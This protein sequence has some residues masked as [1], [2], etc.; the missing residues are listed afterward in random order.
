M[1]LTIQRM[2]KMYALRRI[3]M[4]K[5]MLDGTTLSY[6]ARMLSGE[7]P[8]LEPPTSAVPNEPPTSAEED[9]DETDDHGAAR[10]QRV[11]SHVKLATKPGI[12]FTVSG[13]ISLTVCYCTQN[14]TTQGTCR[15]LQ[16]ILINPGFPS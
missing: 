6:T 16:R 13:D 1:L 8:E 5:H 4:D 9:Q 14:A 10:G 12:H 2:D 3:F 11:L 7:G 15:T